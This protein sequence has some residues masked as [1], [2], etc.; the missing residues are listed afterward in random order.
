V[1]SKNRDALNAL[2]AA[3]LIQRSS[4]E[5]IEVLNKAGVPCGP[6]YKMDEVFADPQV[7]AIGMAKPVTHP[8]LGK[9]E[10]LGQ[11]VHLKRTPSELRTAAPDR[12][13]QSDEILRENGWSDDQIADFRGRGII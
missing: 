12:G 4:S 2:I 5:W 9:I 11:G 8:S 13:Q 3:K 1:R 10:L 6:I 7:Q